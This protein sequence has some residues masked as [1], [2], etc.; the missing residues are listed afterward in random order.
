MVTNQSTL[1]VMDATQFIVEPSDLWTS[2]VSAKHKDRAPR[3]VAMPDGGEGWAYE[4]GAWLR[5]LGLEV[6]AG[7]SPLDFRDH[8]FSYAE[9]RKGMHDARE[10]VKDL[11][12][13]E[14]DAASIFPTYGMDVRNILDADLHLACVRAYNDGLLEWCQTG[15]SKRLLP[16]AMMPASGIE[17][18][19]AEL[20]RV[21][22]LGF[23]GIIFG[24]W[25]AGGDRPQPEV[26]DA[27]WGLCEESGTVISLLK[28][29]PALGNDRSPVAP[30][31]Y[32]GPGA[33]QVRPAQASMEAAWAQS[34]NIKNHN[35]TW[36]VLTGIPDRFPTLNFSLLDSGA[37]WLPTCGELWD[38]LYRYEQFMAFVKLQ[39]MPSIYLK[40]QVRAT[41]NWDRHVMDSRREFGPHALMWSSNYPNNTSSFPAS[42][43]AIEDQTKGISEEERRRIAGENCAELYGV[44]PG[45][46][47]ESRRN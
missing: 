32:I 13:D 38:W 28:G 17:A 39:H 25:P 44:T 47:A 12:A 23:R 35:L 30:Q 2:R 26:E 22:K 31:R 46:R 40:R 5:P 4:G 1:S 14:V 37:G 36:I 45:A 20:E 19:K 9:I 33:K 8:G 15:G 43:R 11:D 7:R 27:F 42:R 34:V 6:C 29:G 16:N 24:G 10:R 21:V 41:L 18:A 3:V